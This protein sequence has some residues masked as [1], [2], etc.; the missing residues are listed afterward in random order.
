MST[1]STATRRPL[2]PW[3]RGCG[4]GYAASRANDAALTHSAGRLLT[5]PPTGCAPCRQPLVR[6]VNPLGGNTTGWK[7]GCGR[8]ACPVRR[9][10]G[11]AYPTLPIPNKICLGR[12]KLKIPVIIVFFTE[13][14]QSQLK[15]NNLL[16]NEPNRTQSFRKQMRYEASLRCILLETKRD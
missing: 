5:S 13:R 1:S 11:V 6:C 16:K 15:T 4:C 9:E 10:G 12:E 8:P 2:P 3:T 14:T 7:A